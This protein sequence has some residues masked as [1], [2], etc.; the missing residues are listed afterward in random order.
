MIEN[1]IRNQLLVFA[2]SFPSVLMSFIGALH[3]M[4]L[5]EAHECVCVCVRACELVMDEKEA[6]RC[7]LVTCI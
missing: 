3:C 5:A 7:C 4:E 2:L 6:G 1:T